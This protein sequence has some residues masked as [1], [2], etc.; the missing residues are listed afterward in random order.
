MPHLT[1]GILAWGHNLSRLAKLQ[2]KAR[3]VGNIRYNDH[4]EPVFKLLNLLKLGNI[5]KQILLKFYYNYCHETL[6]FYF[7]S[8]YMNR[9]MYGRGSKQKFSLLFGDFLFNIRFCFII[10]FKY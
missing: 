7:Q 6:P 2:K 8:F 1:Y 5:Y 10:N 3:I 9:R 4:T